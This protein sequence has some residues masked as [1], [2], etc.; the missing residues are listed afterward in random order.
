MLNSLGH[1]YFDGDFLTDSRTNR[2]FQLGGEKAKGSWLFGNEAE[3]VRGEVPPLEENR[4]D[5][6]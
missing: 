5:H 1:F 6:Q 4:E 2:L 3:R